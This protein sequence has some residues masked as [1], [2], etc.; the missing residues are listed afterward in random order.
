MQMEIR[1]CFQ[2][3]YPVTIDTQYHIKISPVNMILLVFVSLLSLSNQYFTY[4]YTGNLVLGDLF[5]LLLKEI[6]MS[7]WLAFH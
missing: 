4:M 3:Q 6:Y 2:A 1:I 5:C 7:F